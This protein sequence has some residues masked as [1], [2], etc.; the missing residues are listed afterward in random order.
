V[1][2]RPSIS[3]RDTHKRVE[4]MSRYSTG[5]SREERCGSGI[6][7]V[8]ADTVEEFAV[9]NRISRSQTYKEIAAGRLIA[10]KVGARTIITK[11]DGAAWRRA[12]PK[13]QAAESTTA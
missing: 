6:S 3:I 10:R 2:S 4:I 13:M 9:K 5:M 7:D 8:D 12:L 1:E 11:E